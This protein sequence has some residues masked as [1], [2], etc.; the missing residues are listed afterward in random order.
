MVPRGLNPADSRR[1]E[2]YQIKHW[3]DNTAVNFSLS[4]WRGLDEIR[5]TA[6]AGRP[7]T[8]LQALPGGCR[9]CRAGCG[10]HALREYGCHDRLR[11]ARAV[12]SG[13][14]PRRGRSAST[15]IHWKSSRL[16]RETALASIPCGPILWLRRRLLPDES[17]NSWPNASVAKSTLRPWTKRPRSL[18][19]PG[20]ACSMEGWISVCTGPSLNRNPRLT[21]R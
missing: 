3:L 11:H 6:V 21:W 4:L 17:S 19:L 1:R 7:G 16:R 13:S 14:P 20:D 8:P 10:D 5:A 2:N 12:A 9:S 15:R 18:A